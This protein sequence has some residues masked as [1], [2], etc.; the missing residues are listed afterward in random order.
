[1]LRLTVHH[2]I[3]LTRQERYALHQGEDLL[4]IGTS[5]P[6]WT[7]KNITS[8]PGKEVFCYYYLKNPKKEVPIK[9]LPDGYE[10]TIPYREGTKLEISDEEYRRIV[11][12]NKEKLDELYAKTTKE[13][14]SKNLLDIREGGSEF[15]NYRELNTVLVKEKEIQIM[16]HVT[17]GTIEKLEKSFL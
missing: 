7:V 10:I 17:I 9:I 5:L 11:S 4:V 13:V 3:H 16:H 14:S 12:E 6:I 2:N 15:L 1:M 8:E